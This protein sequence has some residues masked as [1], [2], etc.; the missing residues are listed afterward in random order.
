MAAVR[1]RQVLFVL[2]LV[3][4][5]VPGEAWGASWSVVPSPSPDVFSA[6]LGGVSCTSVRWCAAVGHS[7]FGALV[8]RW[9]GTRWAFQAP[10][11]S[12]S[13]IGSLDGV[14][15]SSPRQCTA[16]GTGVLAERWDG[17]RWTIQA[18]PDPPHRS[19]AW[20]A[21]VSCSSA[22]DCIAVGADECASPTQCGDGDSSSFTL[23]EHWNGSG[24]TIQPSLD[25]PGTYGRALSAVSCSSRSDCTAVGSSSG[26]TMIE[27]W[28]GIQWTI[29]PSPNP[30][31]DSALLGVS[32]TSPSECTAVGYSI[33]A[34][35]AEHWDGN[36]W[37][38]EPTPNPPAVS[39][40]RLAGVSCISAADCTAV[41][42][43]DA[44]TPAAPRPTPL[45]E[46]WDGT[47]WT[48]QS[49][50]NLS[51]TSPVE[52]QA[53]TCSSPTQCTAVGDA[54]SKPL[55]LR[56][57][58]PPVTSVPGRVR[59]LG[60]VLKLKITCRGTLQQH[61]QA[62][63]SVAT[64]ETLST[65]G[66]RITGLSATPPRKGH[67]KAVIV[68]T[69]NVT[70][71]AGQTRAISIPLNATGRKLRARFMTVPATVTVT[72]TSAGRKTTIR[73]ARVTFG[74]SQRQ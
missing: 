35:L 21:G 57:T 22:T 56:Y 34:T 48:L 10:A 7:G 46:R 17:T 61:C 41:G 2:V 9:D 72:L 8:E 27:H 29:Q 68:A 71:I 43:A 64:V 55:V 15:C 24:W 26:G 23:A 14:S 59:T 60:S 18:T 1:V 73:T 33:A 3:I 74:A 20:L 16:V 51:A 11:A 58:E 25:P 6:G 44:G 32:C 45:A 62:R 36:N 30:A 70:A 38:I 40:A 37:T 13:T 50:A 49:L 63:V 12:T 66:R 28:N 54:N 69:G 47:R 67:R 65:T 52:L 4:G 5:M 42:T 53:V 19:D 31:G 39:S